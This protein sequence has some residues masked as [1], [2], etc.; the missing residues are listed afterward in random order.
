MP[1]EFI[2][3]A[4]A[5]FE[6]KIIMKSAIVRCAFVATTPIQHPARKTE[7][8]Q[9]DTRAGCAQSIGG[10][11]RGKRGAK[12]EGKKRGFH[13]RAYTRMHIH[14]IVCTPRC[15]YSPVF[16]FRHIPPLT[17]ASGYD[18]PQVTNFSSGRPYIN[19]LK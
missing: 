6:E 7:W 13:M 19:I 17:P 15:T 5:I 14:T 9:R 2:F 8:D 11:R 1:F 10:E 16:R 4:V 12:D 18:L 3:L